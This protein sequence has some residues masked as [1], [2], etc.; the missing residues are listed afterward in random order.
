MVKL[1]SLPSLTLIF[2]AQALLACDIRKRRVL[3]IV[4][5]SFLLQID[6]I[7]VSPNK[8]PRPIKQEVF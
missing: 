3:A 6:Q 7:R 4:L 2:F 8:L 5:L 1:P